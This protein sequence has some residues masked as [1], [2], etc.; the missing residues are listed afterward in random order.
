MECHKDFEH[1]SHETYSEMH[2]G[3][4]KETIDDGSTN[5]LHDL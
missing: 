5:K 4:H 2:D 3:F 1:Q